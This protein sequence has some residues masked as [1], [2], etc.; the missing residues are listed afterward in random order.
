MQKL[1]RASASAASLSTATSS[2]NAALAL[3]AAGPLWPKLLQLI[4]PEHLPSARDIA[5]HGAAITHTLTGT[6][7]PAEAVD[8]TMGARVYHMYLPIFFFAREILRA[9][10]AEAGSSNA[11]AATVAVGLS[12]P[13]GCGKTTLVD[14]LVERFAAE[15]ITCAA[16]SFDDFYLRG[17][18]QDAVAAASP[19]NPLLQVRG[20]AGTHDVELGSATLRALKHSDSGETLAL[21]R[22]D[23]AQRG[24]R[25][26]RAPAD[27]WPA[28]PSPPDIVLLEG[29]MAGFAPVSPSAEALREYQG[30]TEVNEALA[31]Y[32]AWH[33]LMDAWVVVGVDDP[34]VVYQ[35]RLQ[36]ER[37]MA[38]SGRPGMSDAQ[39]ADF[40]S[41]YMPAYHAYLPA[42]YAAAE[43]GG[44]DAK[45]TIFAKVDAERRPVPS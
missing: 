9:R 28:L 42:L 8:A 37:A 17:A 24:G 21:P 39:V 26:D 7:T 44:V 20:N 31:R 25:G 32:K 35:W 16:V 45:P 41:R 10:R 13:Q 34:A 2:A 11:K 22:Y 23:K 27:T 43:A 40:V 30:L 19:S 38:A 4:D 29:W 5:S 14:V 36:A 3:A 6:A 18:E 15:G 12:A 1:F 33:E